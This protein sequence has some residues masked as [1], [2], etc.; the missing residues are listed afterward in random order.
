MSVALWCSG[1]WLPMWGQHVESCRY[2][3]VDK[4][5]PK[6][7]ARATDAKDGS[8]PPPDDRDYTA[9]DYDLDERCEP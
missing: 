8:V 9:F 4:P 3:G 2:R 1:C 5:R 6:R 7:P